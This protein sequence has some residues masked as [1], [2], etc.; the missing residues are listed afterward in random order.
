MSLESILATH[1]NGNFFLNGTYLIEQR[2]ARN[3]SGTEQL[4]ALEDTTETTLAK[5]FG[6]T[7]VAP[8]C[9]PKILLPVVPDP[10]PTLVTT[11]KVLEPGGNK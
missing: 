8:V 10:T 11:S 9:A 1:N 4:V 7:D 6:V 2:P 3:G 5:F